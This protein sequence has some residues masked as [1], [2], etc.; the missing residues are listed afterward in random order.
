MGNLPEGNFDSSPFAA[1]L[2]EAGGENLIEIALEASLNTLK[3]NA[4]KLGRK[5]DQWVRGG[6]TSD[7]SLNLLKSQWSELILNM[8][9]RIPE[10]RAAIFHGMSDGMELSKRLGGDL[11]VKRGNFMSSQLLNG[12]R[13]IASIVTIAGFSRISTISYLLA[14]TFILSEQSLEDT[15]GLC[16]FIKQ[17]K[18][19]P[20]TQDQQIS[21]PA[22]L[23]IWYFRE[24]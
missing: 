4:T 17:L 9:G 1:A 13:H 24:E 18:E 21:I 5:Y 2:K 6:A 14:S 12:N 3:I 19:N 20:N 8:A 16:L 22:I 11:E 23:A 7:E 10:E 15:Q